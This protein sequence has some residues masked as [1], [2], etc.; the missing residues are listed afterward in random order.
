MA[1]IRLTRTF[2]FGS[3]DFPDPDPDLTET[4][5]LEHF[6]GMFPQLRYGKVEETGVEGDTI[7]YVLKPAEYLKNG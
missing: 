3:S 5:V 4:Q 7:V 6:S 1:T 2:R